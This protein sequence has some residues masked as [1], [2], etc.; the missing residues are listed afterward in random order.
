MGAMKDIRLLGILFLALAVRTAMLFSVFADVRRAQTPDSLDYLALAWTM[1]DLDRYAHRISPQPF[2]QIGVPF[3]NSVSYGGNQPEIFRTPGY[4]A[5]LAG[6]DR[7][8]PG[9]AGMEMGRLFRPWLS[10][11]PASLKIVLA[12]QLLLDLHLVLLTFFLGRS[13][14]GHGA[15][16]LAALFQAVSPLAA[17]ASC[18]I[19]TDGIFAFMLTAAVLLLLRHFRTGGWWLLLSAGLVMGAACYVRPVGLAFSAVMALV[20]LFS[21][22]STGV[23]RGTG[24]P[25]STGVP[26]GTGVPR[27]TGILPV[28][29]TGILPVSS[30]AVP[31]L[32][33]KD[34]TTGGTPVELTAETAVLLMGEPEGPGTPMLRRSARPRRLIRTAAFACIVIAC[35]AP[36]VFRN[37]T[38]ADYWGFSSFATESMYW[39]SAAEIEARQQNKPVGEIRKQFE[40]A[41][42]RLYATRWDNYVSG[43]APDTS[44]VFDTPGGLARWRW[45]KAREIIL[46]HPWEFLD[47][48]LRGDL[49]F[50]LPDATEALEVL[51]YTSGGKGTLDVLHR[52]GLIAAAKHYFGDN[53]TAMALAG[54]MVVLLLI[55]YAGIVLCGLWRLRPHMSAGGWLC[56][57]LVLTAWLLPGPANHPRF[58]VPVEPILSAVAAMGWLGLLQWRQ[59]RRRCLMVLSFGAPWATANSHARK[60]VE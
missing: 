19:L 41:E 20:I 11:P 36:W 59:R 57:L 22:R 23:P 9:F 7:L 31:A 16:L 40:D 44:S 29:S 4:P 52:Q 48:H 46:A 21:R 30:M 53:T 24:V 55:R 1:S 14:A 56:L 26:H 3:T 25:R 2:E 42:S 43:Q 32:P 13:L 38:V 37:A 47:I 18:R 58:R 27:S 50:W 28:S 35:I 5:L 8:E 6:A 60:G 51:G 15:G 12:F 54:A 39:Y 45:D 17:A 33:G 34:K 49:A 10:E